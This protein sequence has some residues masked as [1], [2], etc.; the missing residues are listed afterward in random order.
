MTTHENPPIVCDMTT[1]PDTPDE[2][3]AEYQELFDTALVAKERTDTGI[4]FRLRADPGIADHVRDLAAREKACCA[5]FDFTINETSDEVIWDS[6]VIDDPIARQILEEYYNL[7]DTTA[8]SPEA[9]HA[10][11]AAKGLT[12][13]TDDHGVLRPAPTDEE[14]PNS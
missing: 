8:D 14:G 4:R 2:R 7:P 1:A 13:V 10:R 5:F 6:T 3:L 9:L 11:F 12:I